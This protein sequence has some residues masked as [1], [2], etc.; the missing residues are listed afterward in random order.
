MTS[1]NEDDT[2]EEESLLLL[3]DRV[4][5]SHG[6]QDA[7]V[8]LEDIGNHE[9][10][11]TA[12]YDSVARPHASAKLTT[13]SVC[14]YELQEYSKVLA[15]QLVY[16]YGRPDYV[17]A[18][19]FDHVP[20]EFVA[21]LACM[22]ASIPIVPVSMQHS[23][24]LQDILNVLQK[25]RA[26]PEGQNREG[27]QFSREATTSEPGTIKVVAL[28]CCDDDRDP[29]L[30]VFH[31][32]NIHN[33]LYLDGTGNLREQLPVP[34]DLGLSPFQSRVPERKDDLYILFTSGTTA[35]SDSSGAPSKNG[36]VGPKAVIGSH[37]STLQRIQWFHQNFAPSPRVG[38]KTHWTFVGANR[39][40]TKSATTVN[41]RHFLTRTRMSSLFG[42]LNYRWY[43]RIAAN[44]PSPSFGTRC[45][46]SGPTTDWKL[47]RTGKDSDLDENPATNATDTD[48]YTT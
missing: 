44:Y 35:P 41:S 8:V 11:A 3:F 33:I 45:C 47:W 15:A 7:I 20:A 40:G 1:V 34:Q 18:D 2:E 10:L 29:R 22:R 46:Q 38:R 21:L 37:K 48:S 39:R 43:F 36:L 9:H 5:V 32:A 42:I 30:G 16:R 13:T 14:Y 4:C 31:K 12:G 23:P 24:A 19:C 26:S 27:N 25:P 6:D 28:T 17:L